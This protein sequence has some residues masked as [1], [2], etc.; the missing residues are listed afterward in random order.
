[1]SVKERSENWYWTLRGARVWVADK[2]NLKAG[3]KILDVGAGDGV[4]SIQAGQKYKEVRFIGIEYSDEYEE[5]QENARKLGLKNVEF[6]FMNAFD[7]KFKEKFDRVVF[8]ISLRNIP[9][10]QREM[11]ELFEK[12][13]KVLRKNGLLAIAE[14]FKEDANNEAQK[15]AQ[16]IYEECSE[17]EDEH[18]RG[19]EKFFFLKEVKSALKETGFKIILFDKFK[20]GVK[21]PV[22]ES[23]DFI[24][25][26]AGEK[27]WK[28]IWN[29]YRDRIK[30]LGRIE[31]DANISLI[32][33]KIK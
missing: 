18:H 13:K 5:A 11:V 24:K 10:N 29:R 7:I 26:E 2:L 6:H 27:N 12:V 4:F 21:L 19:I 25:D 32:L 23:K 16:K 9:T 28:L 14:M 3:M 15:L 1:M 8:F 17:L 33:A 20:T 30:K 31:P 22:E